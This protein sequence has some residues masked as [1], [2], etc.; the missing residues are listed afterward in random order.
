MVTMET[1]ARAQ[2]LVEMEPN[3]GQG[4][5]SNKRKI[6]VQLA[7]KREQETIETAMFTVAQ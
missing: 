2:S 5:L 4:K 1:G 7:L 3:L 6:M